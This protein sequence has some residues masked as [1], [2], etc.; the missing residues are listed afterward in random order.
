MTCPDCDNRFLEYLIFRGAVA[1]FSG[2]LEQL[3]D[4]RAR[5]LEELRQ[6]DA[7]P[8]RRVNVALADRPVERTKQVRRRADK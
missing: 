8:L 5:I 4:E 1:R 3:E 7:P 2:V 6:P